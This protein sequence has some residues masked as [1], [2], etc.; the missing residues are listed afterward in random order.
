VARKGR[1]KE[2]KPEEPALGPETPA[3]AGEV[4]GTDAG[5][6]ASPPPPGTAGP[7]S[8]EAPAASPPGTEEGRGAPA[9]G[10]EGPSLRER[11]LEDRYL[12]LLADFDNFRK[13]VRRE[14]EELDARIKAE[15]IRRI[16]PILDDYDRAR[17]AAGPTEHPTDRDA[18]LGILGRLAQA[19]EQEGLEPIPAGPGDPFDPEIHEAIGTAPSEH[20]PEHRI[21]EV[22]ER[23]Y[24]FRGKLLRPVRVLVSSG[25]PQPDT[26]GAGE[27]AGRNESPPRGGA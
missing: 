24:R 22:F 27:E 19:L 16:L 7:A 11:E 9:T 8:P 18:L 3:Q 23:G 12:R 21:L 26:G 1:K 25:P 4:A 13:R 15:M 17:G 2:R 20:I 14:Q 6:G 10:E 5:G